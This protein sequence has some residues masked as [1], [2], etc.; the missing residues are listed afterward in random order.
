MRRSAGAFLSWR[1]AH[2][3]RVSGLPSDRASVAEAGTATLRANFT[4]QTAE[5]ELHR[6]MDGAASATNGKS[7]AHAFGQAC[8]EWLR[9]VEHEKQV[10]ES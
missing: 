7:G 6:I 3:T 10:A 1:S 9:Y 4:R 5:V 2:F 8:D